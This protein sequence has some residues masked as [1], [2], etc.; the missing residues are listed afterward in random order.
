MA[1]NYFGSNPK[2]RK[3]Q[4]GERG[5]E[6]APQSALVLTTKIANPTFSDMITQATTIVNF[7]VTEFALE[8]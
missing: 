3:V 7:C 6:W 8:E 4:V 2:K 1:K 5:M